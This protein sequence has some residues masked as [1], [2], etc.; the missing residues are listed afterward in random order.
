MKKA[1]ITILQYVIFLGLGIAIVAYMWHQLSKD[2]I[3]EILDSIKSVHLLLLI[4]IFFVGF[5]SHFFRAIR[6]KL[7]LDTLRIHPTTVNV[8]LAVLIG[9]VTNLMLPRAGEVA[10]C[11]ILAKYEKVPADKMVG[12]IVAERAFD[13][14]CLLIVVAL[15]FILQGSYISDYARAHLSSHMASKRNALI[16]TVLV[17]LAI[18]FSLIF[19]YR[20]NKQSKVGV[21]IKGMGDGV[22]AIIHM[23]KRRA[24]IGYTFLIWIM[25]LLQVYMGFKCLSATADLSVLAALVV[26]VFGSVGMITTQGGI[27]AYPFL[28]AQIL[29]AYNV[30]NTAGLA[31]GW[32]AW[33]VQTGIIVI[34]GVLALIILPIYNRNKYAQSP[35]APK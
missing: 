9:Y 12:T 3:S 8:T 29:L 31:F 10:K 22:R 4:P 34:L 26:L 15:A 32:L 28:V 19:I 2:E 20:R 25:Y 5:L 7:L 17:I 33:V 1:L 35:L 18:I 23:R 14:L 13:I 21:F 30:K 24:F 27:G 11:T 6:W 16:I